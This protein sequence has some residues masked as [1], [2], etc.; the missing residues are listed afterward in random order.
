MVVSVRGHAWI[1]S[2]AR[3]RVEWTNGVEAN[4]EKIED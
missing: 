4:R 3:M 2:G 1:P